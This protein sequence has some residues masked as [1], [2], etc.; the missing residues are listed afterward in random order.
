MIKQE[1]EQCAYCDGSHPTDRFS[2]NTGLYGEDGDWWPA[3]YCPA[4][5]SEFEIDERKLLL[6]L[7]KKTHNETIPTEVSKCEVSKCNDRI[8]IYRNQKV[9]L[10]GIFQFSTIVE[11]P[12]QLG[13]RYGGVIAY[14][15]A[16]IEYKNGTFEAVSYIFL[17]KGQGESE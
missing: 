6:S 5:G 2:P 10:H 16:V 3:N 12:V 7:N 17:S 13:G 1:S 9:Y 15:T 14:P 8:Y 4:C 11:P